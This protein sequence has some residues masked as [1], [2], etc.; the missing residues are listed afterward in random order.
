MA[1]R[2]FFWLSWSFSM[3]PSALPVWRPQP[4]PGSTH[5]GR[6]RRAV[7]ASECV[8]KLA[9]ERSELRRERRTARDQHIVEIDLEVVRPHVRD[10]CLEAPP[11]AIA[12]DRL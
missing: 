4:R 9:Y 5:P 11:D 8:G 3:G 10:R 6:R 7:H 12:L 1:R 2:R